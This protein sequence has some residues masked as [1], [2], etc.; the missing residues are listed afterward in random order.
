MGTRNGTK[1]AMSPFDYLIR[2]VIPRNMVIDQWKEK[3]GNAFLFTLFIMKESDRTYARPIA[4]IANVVAVLVAVFRILERANAFGTTAYAG[5]Q[6]NDVSP[7]EWA[8]LPL[9]LFGPS[10]FCFVLLP[11]AN[12]DFLKHFER[13]FESLTGDGNPNNFPKNLHHWT[14]EARDWLFWITARREAMQE[15]MRQLTIARQASSRYKAL[16][17]WLL[18]QRSDDGVRVDAFFES[19]KEFG[20]TEWSNPGQCHVDLL[21]DD[22]LVRQFLRPA[23]E[24]VR[25]EAK[26]LKLDFPQVWEREWGCPIDEQVA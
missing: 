12:K 5:W 14:N 6:W 17:E 25:A 3:N 10:L 4:M 20:V 13:M 23:R 7:I 22:G 9:T 11:L 2:G 1:R 18:E 19:A 16:N 15:A 8:V 26:K 24:K 21:K